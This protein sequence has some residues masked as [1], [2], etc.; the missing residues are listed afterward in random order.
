[1]LSVQC[2][3]FMP[4]TLSVSLSESDSSTGSAASWSVMFSPYSHTAKC[5]VMKFGTKNPTR[6]VIQALALLGL[7]H[8]I[9]LRG[10]GLK[11]SV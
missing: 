6:S 3:K 11:C 5:T 9:A 10:K 8:V 1:V 4:V 7:S 2:A